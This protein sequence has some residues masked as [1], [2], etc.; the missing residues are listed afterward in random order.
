VGI[1]EPSVSQHD[2][3]FATVFKGIII[4]LVVLSIVILILALSI[5]GQQASLQRQDAGYQQ[6][7]L[8][9]IE[10][11]GRV[12]TGEPGTEPPPAKPAAPA[13]AAAAPLSG[14]EVV[15]ASCASCHEAGILNAPKLGDKAAWEARAAQGFDTLVQHAIQGFRGMPPKGGNTA[16][17]DAQVREA[18]SVMLGQAGLAIGSGAPA[19]QAG[20]AAPDQAAAP[21]PAQAPAPAPQPQAAASA[22]PQAA[23]QQGQRDLARGEKVYA[24][25]CLT[26]HGTGVMGAPKL[27]DKAAWDA[28]LTQGMD[29]L[30]K[31]AVE[32]FQGQQGVMPPKGGYMA[33]SDAQVADAVAYMAQQ[34]R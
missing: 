2:Q 26:C 28:R 27:G 14:E 33:L 17:T 19:G 22:P 25:A 5:G 1:K 31:H 15:K 10:P 12:N 9:R 6:A 34:A 7:L 24:E 18:V 21:A 29:T 8:E 16:L 32:G 20:A 4:F 30:V 3:Q 11:V 23:A 13:Q